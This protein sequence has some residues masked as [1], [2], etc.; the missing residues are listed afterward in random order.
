M[1]LGQLL[2]SP[3]FTD[4]FERLRRD[5]GAR[6]I[7]VT[8]AHGAEGVTSVAASLACSLSG[9]GRVLLAEGNL[10]KPSLATELGLKGCG[11][12]DWDLQGPLPTQAMPG[13]PEVAVLT[14]GKSGATLNAV[15]ALSLQARLGAAAQ[16]A[17]EDF[18]YVVWDT[19]AATRFPDLLA[20]ARHCDGVLVVIEMDRSRVDGLH[21]LRDTLERARVPILGS[22]LNRSGRYWPPQTR[23]P[24]AAL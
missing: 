3:A 22:V 11:L 8:G 14:A 9:M 12:L 15:D 4:E 6:H 10:R 21:Y 13:H 18:A 7:A 24:P 1:K 2:Q 20:V 19:P 5:L 23:Y 16:R 17:R